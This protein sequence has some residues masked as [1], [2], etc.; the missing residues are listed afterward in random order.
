MEK[1]IFKSLGFALFGRPNPK[2]LESD[3]IDFEISWMASLNFVMSSVA[4]EE[5]EISGDSKRP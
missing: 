3:G 4:R 2:S 5:D 1:M